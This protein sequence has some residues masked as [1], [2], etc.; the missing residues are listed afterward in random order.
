MEALESLPRN[1]TGKVFPISRTALSGLWN[2]A[3]KRAEIED[4][5]FHAL[6]HE[7]TSRIFENGANVVEMASVIDHRD[8]RMLIRYTHLRAEN[9]A[10]KWDNN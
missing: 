3:C 9:L 4:L 5:N 2:K 6:R 8:L 10:V 7:A 1:T